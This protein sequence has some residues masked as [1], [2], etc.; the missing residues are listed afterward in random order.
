MKKLGFAFAMLVLSAQA[1]GQAI[2]TA[3]IPG[4]AGGSVVATFIQQGGGA[5]APPNQVIT[6][7]INS[8]NAFSINV[9]PNSSFA[10][11]MW[12]FRVCVGSGINLVCYQTQTVINSSGDISSLFSGAPAPGIGG[13]ASINGLGGNF[14]FTGSVGCT[15]T[16]GVTTC[17]F[18]GGGGSGTPG[19]TAGQVQFNSA[20]SFGGFTL[21]GDAT[22]NTGTG[23]LTVTKTNGTV[24]GFGATATATG[25][26]QILTT[27]SS[28][29]TGTAVLGAISMNLTSGVI[30]AGFVG[31]LTGN[32]TTATSATSATTSTNLAGGAV[33]S[34]FYQSAA[35]TTSILSPNTTTTP[36]FLTQ[37]GTGGAG[38]APVWTTTIPSSS[39]P[40]ASSSAFG[41]VQ[42]DGVT[43]ACSSGVVSDMTVIASPQQSLAYYSAVGTSQVLT[44]DATASTD[45]HGNIA[46][47]TESTTVLN[48]TGTGG[49]NNMALEG[50]CDAGAVFSSLLC[51]QASNHRWMVNNNNGGLK[52]I[53][54]AGVDINTSDQVVSLHLPS[55]ITIAQGGTN[56]SAITPSILTDGASV[57]FSGG[58]SITAS[59]VLTLI[60]TTTTRTLTV[61]SMIA[62][63]AYWLELKQDSTG[64]A[65]TFTLGTGCTWKVGGGG[66]GAITLSSTANAIDMLT[67]V[68]DGT[69]CIANFRTNFN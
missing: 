41:A 2:V 53:A 23:A 60:H 42:C 31:P 12:N 22:L 64:V 29:A 33:G 50:T 44:G 32:A 65:S 56:Q 52:Q 20:G 19:G 4:Y 45:G 59:S 21:G 5:P 43:I 24:F 61:A 18:T 35:N 17:N 57:S 10:P 46:D 38:T 27:N 13:V 7:I 47:V 51:T 14:L 9:T 49:Y 25:T 40:L 58:S 39:L 48:L 1:F 8:S 37:T 62:G 63:A 68:Y 6:G 55:P 66:A 26:G 16:S 67:W 36:A 11:S 34:I 3:T 15:T 30:T 69:N 28:S 54:L